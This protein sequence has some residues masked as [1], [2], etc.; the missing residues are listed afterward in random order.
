MPQSW[1]DINRSADKPD[2]NNGTPWFWISYSAMCLGHLLSPNP[3]DL[4]R[5]YSKVKDHQLHNTGILRLQRAAYGI[6]LRGMRTSKWL[7]CNLRGHWKGLRWWPH[8]GDN[9]NYKV[10]LA[11]HNIWEHAENC[12]VGITKATPKTHN[13]RTQQ[14]GD[15]SGS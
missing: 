13:P 3:R 12:Y 2:K 9:H 15:W 10:N 14:E 4:L 11:V 8:A 7:G 6:D 1:H 5:R